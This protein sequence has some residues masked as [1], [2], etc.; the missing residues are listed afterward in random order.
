MSILKKEQEDTAFR[1]YVTD[2]LRLLTDN[3]AKASG[4]SKVS[5]RWWDIIHQP[6]PETRTG[7]EIAQD[8]IKRAGLEVRKKSELT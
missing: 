6:A 7:A 5:K 2:T 8:V 4:G 1:I 3:T